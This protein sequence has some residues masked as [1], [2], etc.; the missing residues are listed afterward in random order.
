MS[1]TMTGFELDARGLVCSC[2]RCGRRNRLM[3]EHLGRIFRCGECRSELLLPPGPIDAR[4][5]AEFEA[6]VGKSSLPVV[7]D[8]WAPWCG[9]CKMV[10]PEVAKV[11]QEGRGRWLVVKVDTEQLPEIADRLVIRGIPTL[12]VFHQ[13]RELV[14]QSGAMP[15]SA[16]E[17]FVQR[18]LQTADSVSPG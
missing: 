9:P 13:G 10:A 16:I 18:A 7:V 5:A 8:F 1:A 3:F 14:R 4:T 12:A 6:V 15:A 2:P 17:K 11:A